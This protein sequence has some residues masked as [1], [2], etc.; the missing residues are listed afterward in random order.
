MELTASTRW[1]AAPALRGRAGENARSSAWR[2]QD[3]PVAA[4]HTPQ[5][6]DVLEDL[7]QQ[8]PLEVLEDALGLL[9][10]PG[11]TAALSHPPVPGTMPPG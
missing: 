2:E 11:T 1:R 8:D 7:A 6:R 5:D 4:A 9:D 10:E 3:S